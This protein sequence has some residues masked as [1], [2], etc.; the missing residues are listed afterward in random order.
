MLHHQNGVLSQRQCAHRHGGRDGGDYRLHAHGKGSGQRDGPAF[1]LVPGALG[2]LRHEFRPSRL[3][4]RTV[5]GVSGTTKD[6]AGRAGGHERPAQSRTEED[7]SAN[8]AEWPVDGQMNLTLDTWILSDLVV[9][10]TGRISPPNRL[11]EE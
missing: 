3:P 11:A 5:Q 4:G 6:V 8:A 1:R 10:R 9:G 2:R 7:V